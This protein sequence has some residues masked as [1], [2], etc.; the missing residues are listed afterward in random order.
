MVLLYQVYD[1]WLK[2]SE[3]E[4]VGRNKHRSDFVRRLFRFQ[5]LTPIKNP[6]VRTSEPES[7]AY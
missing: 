5:F 1:F 3:K 7:G 2:R 6:A 4:N